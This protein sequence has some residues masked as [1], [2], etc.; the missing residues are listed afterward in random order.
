MKAV[1]DIA[2]PP[3]TQNIIRIEFHEGMLLEVTGMKA[4]I[5]QQTAAI[6]RQIFKIRFREYLAPTIPPVYPTI[7]ARDESRNIIY[8]FKFELMEVIPI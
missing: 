6:K 1:D 5:M 3:K 4:T 8:G 2:L 7:S